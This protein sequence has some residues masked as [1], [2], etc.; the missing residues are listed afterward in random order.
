MVEYTHSI[1]WFS[2]LDQMYEEHLSHPAIYHASQFWEK[3]NRLNIEWLKEDGF[4]NFKRTVNNNYF[5]WMV[6]ARSTYF[7]NVARRYVRDAMRNPLMLQDLLRVNIGD[8]FHRTYVKTESNSSWHQ[9]KMYSWYLLFLYYFVK[10]S[11]EIG[12][13]NNL[14]EPLIGNPITIR[15]DG[16]NISQDI[17]NSYLEY[18]Y[19][20]Q[21][22]GDNFS[23]V[24]TIAELGGGY[25]RLSYLFHHLHH[26][27][28]VR[29]VLVDLPPALL[30]AQWYLSTVCPDGTIMYYRR[31]SQYSEIKEEF[32]RASICFLLPH[33][34]QLLPEHSV[35]LLINVSSLHEMSRGQ[36][37]H[38]YEVI[39]NKARF[40]YT[41]QWLFWENPEDKM[42]VPS[43]IYPTRANWELVNARFNPIHSDFF[44]ALFKL[45]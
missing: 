17:S 34:L 13:F 19:I 41:K 7:Q 44:E 24:K 3:L 42:L 23:A 40:F 22:L 12:L 45:T 4:D 15:I 18:S 36:I 35:D 10:K 33:Q 21:S 38:Y 25:G 39:N 16:K 2:L 37:N 9:R 1:D 43:I 20:R 14:Q 32:E 8:M 5:N 31:F 11:D 29:I 27:D 6:S 30:V 28:G 26:K